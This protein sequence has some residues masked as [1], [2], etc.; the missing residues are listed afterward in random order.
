MAQN[1]ELSV[2]MSDLINCLSD[3][4][5]LVSPQLADHHNR[6]G[7]IACALACRLG[8]PEEERIDLNFAGNLH[9]IGAL[10]LTDRIRLQSFEPC[11]P[12]KHAETGALLLE[13]FT[14]LARLADLVR[15]HHVL[16]NY[17]AGEV[18]HGREV[19]IGSHILHLAD[20][21]SVLIGTMD[22]INLLVPNP[23]QAPQVKLKDG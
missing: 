22:G 16:W 3:T 18:Q 5:D 20:R 2:P 17:G 8:L 15:Y 13:M 10:S 14:P 9:D 19:S 21:I 4:I 12:H 7:R 6:V 11:E 1:G 23:I